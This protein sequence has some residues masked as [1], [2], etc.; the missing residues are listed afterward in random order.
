[1]PQ[2]YNQ[3]SAAFAIARASLLATLRSPTSVVFSILFP[4]I[5]IV[6]FGSMVDNSQVNIKVG[7]APGCDT[8]NIVF[9]VIKSISIIKPQTNVAMDKMMDDLQKGQIT[10]IL[11]VMNDAP[12]SPFPHYRISL[13]TS[14]SA[15]NKLSLLESVINQAVSNMNEKMFPKSPTTATVAI[16]TIP[17]RLYRQIDFILP[18]QLGFSLLMAGVFGSSFLLFGLRQN[19]VLKRFFATPISRSYLILG[20]L[21][22]RLFFQVIGFS[23]MVALGYLA[24]NFTLVN[25]LFTFLE[26]LLL[27]VIALIIFLGIGFVISGIVQN[28]SSIA[29]VANTIT[30][31]QILLCGL[32]FPVDSYPH[33]LET[34]CKYLP[35]TFFVDGLRKIAFEGLH[36]WQIPE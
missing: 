17:G 11:N 32:F 15:I 35:L 18:G 21:L 22:S 3:L 26:M 19:Q 9:K 31:P 10:A 8:G 33:W 24:F 1:M 36:I 14:N 5:F 23:I 2:D 29:P 13:T 4:I 28:E 34:F 27:S 12:F 30:L 6:V 20:E 25:G 7:I 16:T